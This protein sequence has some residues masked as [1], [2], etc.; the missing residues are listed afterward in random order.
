MI[1]GNGVH[2]RTSWGYGSEFAA[3]GGNR[4][5]RE[6][7]GPDFGEAEFETIRGREGLVQLRM[8]REKRKN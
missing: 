2:P 1:A 8:L 7:I 6:I 5:L 4:D 3:A